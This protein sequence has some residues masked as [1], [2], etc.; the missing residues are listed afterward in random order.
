MVRKILVTLIE[1]LLIILVVYA[2]ITILNSI[3]FAEELTEMYVICQPGDYVNV[4]INPSKK[5]QAVGYIECG[6]SFLTDGQKQNVFIHCYGIGEAGEGWIHCGYVVEDEPVKVN[7]MAFSISKAK[8]AARKFIGGIVRKWL[9][10]LDKVMVYW[11][12]DV[13][14]VTNKGFVMTEYLE[15]EGN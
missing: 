15:M 1:V 7:R 4:R 14:C 13:W 2:A 12:T 6:E 8:L 11:M 9:K 3:S 10:N 5:S